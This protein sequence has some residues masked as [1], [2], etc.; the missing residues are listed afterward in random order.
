MTGPTQVSR[1]RSQRPAAS[2]DPNLLANLLTSAAA[3]ISEQLLP[4]TVSRIL[5]ALGHHF[6]RPQMPKVDVFGVV[7]A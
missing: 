7:A 4:P 5:E 2:I 6:G 3:K 1:G